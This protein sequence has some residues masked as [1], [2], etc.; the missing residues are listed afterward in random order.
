MKIYLASYLQPQ[1]HGPGRKIAIASSKPDNLKVSAFVP[2]IPEESSIVKYNVMKQTDPKAAAEY[3]QEY[4]ED[5]LSSFFQMIV[6]LD[7]L[8]FEDGDT[9][10]SWERAEYTSYRPTLAKYLEKAGYEV[11]LK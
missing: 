6:S 3:F 10:L 4:Y 5:R 8:P 7:Q 1:N 2:F 11:I 9:L